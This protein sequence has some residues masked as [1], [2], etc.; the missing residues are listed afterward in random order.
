M[1]GEGVSWR[2]RGGK[3]REEWVHGEGEEGQKRRRG[4]EKEGV[5]RH[6]TVSM[7]CGLT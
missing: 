7:L 6:C 1:E 2:E 3:R 4:E 5:E